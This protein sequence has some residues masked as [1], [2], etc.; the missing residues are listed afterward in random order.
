MGQ[1]L[2]TA[3]LEATVIVCVWLGFCVATNAPYPSWTAIGF[4]VVGWL[5]MTV[6]RYRLSTR[7]R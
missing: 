3:V 1:A 5:A 4:V 2:N 6:L 7:K